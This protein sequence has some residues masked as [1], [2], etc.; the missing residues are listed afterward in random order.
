[1]GGPAFG[2]RI[3][4]T[5]TPNEP[6]ADPDVVPSGDPE[7]DADPDLPPP[8]EPEVTP[9]RHESGRA[10]PGTGRSGI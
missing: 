4:M 9:V 8:T 5:T 7:P 10:E 6:L 3:E 1:M 2:Y